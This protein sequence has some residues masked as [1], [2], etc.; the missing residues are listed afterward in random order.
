MIY[1][2]HKFFSK[3]IIITILP[4]TRCMNEITRN[5]NFAFGRVIHTIC[6]FLCFFFDVI[7]FD[8]LQMQNISPNMNNLEKYKK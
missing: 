4:N 3:S 6:S 5:F 1:K 8:I 7:K 2:Y